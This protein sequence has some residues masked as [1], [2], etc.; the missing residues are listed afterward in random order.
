VPDRAG[1]FANLTV[2]EL[3][4]LAQWASAYHAEAIHGAE[5]GNRWVFARY[6]LHTRRLN[7]WF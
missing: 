2:E 6:L 3:L 7:E 1:P 5:D 4:R